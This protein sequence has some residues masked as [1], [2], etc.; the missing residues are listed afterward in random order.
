MEVRQ[1]Y[2]KYLLFC[3]CI[4]HFYGIGVQKEPVLITFKRVINIVVI[5]YLYSPW[6][7]CK[8]NSIFTVLPFHSAIFKAIHW[9]CEESTRIVHN[10]FH[11]GTFLMM[12]R[13]LFLIRQEN[14]SWLYSHL[15]LKNEK[16]NGV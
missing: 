13:S 12:Q 1:A 11:G 6:I 2:F 4:L 10:F 14:E 9:C 8:Q 15:S 3:Y 16:G 7:L 5:T